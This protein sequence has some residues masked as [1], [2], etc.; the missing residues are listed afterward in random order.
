MNV[1]AAAVLAETAATAAGVAPS[2]WTTVPAGLLA[3]ATVLVRPVWYRLSHL[4][5]VAH[6]GG[7]ALAAFLTGRDVLEVRIE[8]DGSGSTWHFGR[9]RGIGRVFVAASGYTAP[10][11][12]GLASAALLAAGNT[13][14]DLII[15][16]AALLSLL[17]RLEGGFGVLVVVTAVASLV[18]VARNA[19]SGLQVAFACTVTW[20]ML[21]SGVRSLGTL[22]RARRY[23]ESTDADTLGRLTHLPGLVWVGVFYAVDLYCLLFGARL[24]LGGR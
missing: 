20:F 4:D 22:R 18:L 17:L 19:G 9:P 8:T 15:V 3:L 24:L 2:R 5:T 11:L 21:F 1:D 6:E 16:G 10:S 7:H 23:S 12:F 14:A 13:T